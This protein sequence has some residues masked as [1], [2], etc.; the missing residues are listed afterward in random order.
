MYVVNDIMNNID[1]NK[2]KLH[3]QFISDVD[4]LKDSTICIVLYELKLR[5][6]LN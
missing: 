4:S 1:E 2:Q 6:S 5:I 3:V